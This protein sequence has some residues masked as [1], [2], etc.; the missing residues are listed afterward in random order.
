MAATPEA[1]GVA[2]YGLS[3]SMFDVAQCGNGGT[4]YLYYEKAVLNAPGVSE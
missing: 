4:Q 3:S 2:L 1:A